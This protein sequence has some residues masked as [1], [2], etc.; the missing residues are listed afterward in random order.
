MSDIENS[1]RTEP[2]MKILFTICARAGS[3]GIKN[4]NLREMNGIPLVL[5]T[6]A[7]IKL[8][9]QEHP[10]NLV[11]I[12]LNTDS[13]ELIRIVQIQQ[14]VSGIRFIK[15]QPE[16]ADDEA[17]KVDVIKS[18][19]M[20]CKVDRNYD[21]IVDLDITSPM[22]RVKDIEAAIV[23]L[24]SKEHPDLV[25][26]VVPARRNPYF[27]MVEN[28]GDCYKKICRSNY[29]ARQ[30]A[31]E[32]Y[33]LNASIY[34]YSPDFLDSIIDKTILDY[35]CQIVEMPD[36][37]VLDLDSEEDFENMSYLMNFFVNRDEELKQ[38]IEEAKMS[39]ANN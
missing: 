17:A 38:V 11:D 27:N 6:L 32:V 25:F 18:S 9:M 20:V 21:A 8:Y 31:P 33:D 35:R 5:Y 24:L 1:E 7:V 30:Q 26:S 13:D 3:K 15:R 16:L 12:S 36:Y 19:Y 29:T 4:K 34:A 37:L 28:V 14:I 23:G 2:T 39:M 10:E 22:R